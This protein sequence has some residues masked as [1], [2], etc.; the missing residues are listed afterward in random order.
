MVYDSLNERDERQEDVQTLSR[1]LMRMGQQVT[2]TSMD[3]YHSGMIAKNHYNAVIIMINW[4]GMKFDNLAF[5]HDRQAF[6]G[7][8]L[9]I[10]PG[11]TAD[12][13]KISQEI[14][15]QSISNR[16]I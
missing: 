5:D 1:L 16:L 2:V 14:G 4:P 6:N 12:E 11:L 10:G 8:K 15:R 9:H 13:Q 7:K 3:D